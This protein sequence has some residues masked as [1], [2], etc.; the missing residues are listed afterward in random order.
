M[1]WLAMGLSESGASRTER[2]VD[3]TVTVTKSDVGSG[4]Q[5]SRN[6]AFG[7]FDRIDGWEPESEK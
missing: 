5:S 2:V 1:T 4:N 3:W 6:V 7:G